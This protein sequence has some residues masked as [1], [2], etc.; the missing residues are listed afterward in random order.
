MPISYNNLIGPRQPNP[1]IRVHRILTLLQLA[2]EAGAVF[3]LTNFPMAET[4]SLLQIRG[5]ADLAREWLRDN[6]IPVYRIT[7]TDEAKALEILFKYTDKDF[8]YVDATSFAAMESLAVHTAFTFDQHFRQ[9]GWQ[10]W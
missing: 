4:Y 9:Y 10:A 7:Q 5:G 1:W 3:I 8:S 2:R 6:D